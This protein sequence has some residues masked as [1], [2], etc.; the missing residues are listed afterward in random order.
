LTEYVNSQIF[1]IIDTDFVTKTSVIIMLQSFFSN[2]RWLEIFSNSIS[3]QQK[4]Q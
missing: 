2:L 1:H 4:W 3:T